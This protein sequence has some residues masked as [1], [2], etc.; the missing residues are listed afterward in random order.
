MSFKIVFDQE[1]PFKFLTTNCGEEQIIQSLSFHHMSGLSFVG[2][3]E[4]N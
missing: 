4:S 1:V 3:V 2:S